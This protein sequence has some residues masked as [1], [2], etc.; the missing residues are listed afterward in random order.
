MAKAN[1][2]LRLPGSMILWQQ[3]LRSGR[4]LTHKNTCTRYTHT[5]KRNASKLLT[6]KKVF[7]Y[8]WERNTS[9]M[10]AIKKVFA[11]SWERQGI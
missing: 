10:L 9:K 8:F 7:G 11:V 4:V 5:H 3:T 2:N 1:Y 6:T